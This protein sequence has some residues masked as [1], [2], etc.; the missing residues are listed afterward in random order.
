MIN[1]TRGN[2]SLLV[3]L[4]VFLVIVLF[5]TGLN[6]LILSKVNPLFVGNDARSNSTFDK[7]KER[8]WNAIDL[9]G[10]AIPIALAVGFVI[11]MIYRGRYGTD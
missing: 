9:T 6:S 10:I 4:M 8:S 2:I 1:D 5:S 11:F 7:I 3:L